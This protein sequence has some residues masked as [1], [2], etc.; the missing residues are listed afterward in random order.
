MNPIVRTPWPDE[1]SRLK[2]FLSNLTNTGTTL[3]PIVLA[4]DHSQRILGVAALTINSS[5]KENN[6]I[7]LLVHIR[8]KYTQNGQGQR[9]IDAA[10]HKAASLGYAKISTFPLLDAA[11]IP[12]LKEYG[13]ETVRTEELWQVSL[14]KM[15]AR[16]D[17]LSSRVK[18]PKEWNIRTPEESDLPRLIELCQGYQ[19]LEAGRIRFDRPGDNPGTFFDRAL[20]SVIE[21]EGVI[22][23]ALLIKGGPG[24]NG[25]IDIRLVEPSMMP[26]SGLANFHLF[27]HSMALGLVQGYQKTSFTINRERDRETLNLA[28]R[29]GARRL[30]RKILLQY[31]II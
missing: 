23:A 12:L 6:C 9:L 13:F 24:L 15:K 17:R 1:I 10:V 19:F 30:Q 8:P 11:C 4:C 28:K 7:E 29:S 3:Y 26:F 27:K 2:Y 14:S 21:K 22:F 25:H 31:Q 16:L 20:C 5:T 18:M